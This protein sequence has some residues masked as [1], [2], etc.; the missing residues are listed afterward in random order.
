M[1]NVYMLAVV[2]G[3]VVDMTDVK[4]VMVHRENNIEKVEIMAKEGR[5]I[6]YI[7]KFFCGHCGGWIPCGCDK[8][9]PQSD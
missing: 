4:T 6:D 9:Y 1:G 2:N 5:D 7:R 8:P 3:K